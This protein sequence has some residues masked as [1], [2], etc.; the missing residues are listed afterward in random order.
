MWSNPP[1][2]PWNLIADANAVLGAVY[3][4]P[5][6]ASVPANAVEQSSTTNSLGGTTTVY[7]IPEPNL[8]LL[9]PLRNAGVPA[10]IVNTL[11]AALTPV[12][13]SGYSSVTPNAG[14]YF[15]QGRAGV[16]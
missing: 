7:M 10:P 3:H 15:S 5:T 1:D 9:Q 16:P 6:A 4:A 2:R 14:P 13:N 8:P 12:V 11:N